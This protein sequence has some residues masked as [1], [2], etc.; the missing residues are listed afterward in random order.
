MDMK[1]SRKKLIKRES[2]P[3]INMCPDLKRQY[4]ITC[5]QDLEDIIE[6]FCPYYAVFWS[7]LMNSKYWKGEHFKHRPEYIIRANLALEQ[8]EAETK[9]KKTVSFDIFNEILFYEKNEK[10]KQYDNLLDNY[11]LEDYFVS[12]VDMDK[13][14][15][16][17]ANT[18]TNEMDGAS[19]E[20]GM[21]S[22]H[23]NIQEYTQN[24][25]QDLEMMNGLY[26]F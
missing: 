5:E 11:L 17:Y 25:F 20:I 1:G 14:V 12:V 22:R 16:T 21:Q 7:N 19:D 2:Q 18:Y 26:F 4:T 3:Y 13:D 8:L 6:G 9:P 10:I 23:E 24:L 15:Y